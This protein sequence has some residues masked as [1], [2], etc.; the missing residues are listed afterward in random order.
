MNFVGKLFVTLI[1]VMSVSFMAIG[2]GVNRT[3]RDLKAE[4]DRLR[5]DV[6]EAKTRYQDEQTGLVNR[7]RRLDAALQLEQQAAL[8]QLLKLERE[9]VTL[10][11][12]NAALADELD[13]LR[14][15]RG[16]ATARVADAQQGNLQ[17]AADVSQLRTDIQQNDEARQ[18]AF[19][20]ALE[21]TETLHQLQ[22]Q[23]ERTLER[24]RDLRQDLGQEQQ[25]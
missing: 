17:L 15:Q 7:H 23:L 4:A 1:L 18:Q 22:G 13:T 2:L 6:T 20:K 8:D 12:R 3:H 9:F 16:E 21:D 25:R 19:D 5:E 14:D 10:R 11:H 24:R